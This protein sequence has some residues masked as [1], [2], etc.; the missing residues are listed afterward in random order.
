MMTDKSK[1]KSN[2]VVESLSLY[3]QWL[4]VDGKMSKAVS[5]MNLLPLTPLG[6]TQNC[7][8]ITFAKT[9]IAVTV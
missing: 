7:L 3:W 9:N 4:E 8:L 2:T 1:E 6:Y 5:D